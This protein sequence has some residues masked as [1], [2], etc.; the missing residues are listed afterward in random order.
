MLILPC[1]FFFFLQSSN[2]HLIETTVDDS[3]LVAPAFGLYDVD[4]VRGGGAVRI[5]SGLL[6][7]VFSTLSRC[8]AVPLDGNFDSCALSFAATTGLC[9][10]AVGG[11]ISGERAEISGQMGDVTSTTTGTARSECSGRANVDAAEWKS[12]WNGL[13]VDSPL[14]RC[15]CVYFVYFVRVTVSSSTFTDTRA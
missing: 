3:H 14:A 6:S 4:Y 15:V 9:A 12:E 1:Y 5:V 13:F 11:A 8:S 10:D 7:V 2:V